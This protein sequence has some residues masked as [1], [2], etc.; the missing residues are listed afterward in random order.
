MKESRAVQQ[1]ERPVRGELVTVKEAT[2]RIHVGLTTL[3][4]AI[5]KGEISFFRAPRGRILIDSSDLDNWLR[6]S[7]VSAGTAPGHI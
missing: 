3:Y 4:S 5:H 7:K 6:V 2:K 1:E